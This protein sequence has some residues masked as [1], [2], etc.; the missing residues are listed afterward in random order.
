MDP[1]TT[2]DLMASAFAD[3][4]TETAREHARDLR[5]WIARGGFPPS[6]PGIGELI[7]RILGA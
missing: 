6:R 2:Y 1:D 3:G 5:E 7:T 4:D